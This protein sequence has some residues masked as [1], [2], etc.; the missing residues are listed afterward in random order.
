MIVKNISTR[1]LRLED[2][3]DEKPLLPGQQADLSKYSEAERM[4]SDQLQNFFTKRELVCLGYART[5]PKLQGKSLQKTPLTKYHYQ[6]LENNTILVPSKTM[7]PINNYAV[8]RQISTAVTTPERYNSDALEQYKYEL[9]HDEESIPAFEEK[10]FEGSRMHSFVQVQ[11]EDQVLTLSIDENTGATFSEEFFQP[12]Q[13]PT[14]YA[15]DPNVFIDKAIYSQ[16]EMENPERQKEILHERLHKRIENKIKKLCLFPRTDG[17]PCKRSILP[18]F[19]RCFGHLS[20]EDKQKFYE[21]KAKREKKS[22]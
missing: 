7:Q 16:E 4:Q 15:T 6:E 21:Q 9:E 19:N 18:G 12:G 8:T 17:K 3:P 2:F 1:I 11:S 14:E 13:I 5:S 22:N 20:K 10:D